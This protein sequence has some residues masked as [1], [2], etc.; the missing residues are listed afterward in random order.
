MSSRGGGTSSL[1]CGYASVV[2]RT[3]HLRRSQTVISTYKSERCV[4]SKT[5]F[6]RL[7]CQSVRQTTLP[8]GY[9]TKKT[10]WLA[11]AYM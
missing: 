5:V 6:M 7:R 9:H 10:V 8:H 4:D 3:N 1:F 11:A 2:Y